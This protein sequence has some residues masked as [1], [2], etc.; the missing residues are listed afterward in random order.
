MH[1]LL[2][3]EALV[4]KVRKL[5]IEFESA[6]NSNSCDSICSIIVRIESNQSKARFDS[7][8]AER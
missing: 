4:A 1:G 7:I 5:R 8:R 3:N 6:V 2:P